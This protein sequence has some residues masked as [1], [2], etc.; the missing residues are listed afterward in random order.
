[1]GLIAI[2]YIQRGSDMDDAGFSPETIEAGRKGNTESLFLKCWKR[3]LKRHLQL[4]KNR[5]TADLH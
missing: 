4:N 3:F 5:M 1:M 2:H